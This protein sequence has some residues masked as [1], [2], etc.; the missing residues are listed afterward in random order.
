MLVLPAAFFALS[1]CA[2]S[3]V[4][5]NANQLKSLQRQADD[6]E[7]KIGGMNRLLGDLETRVAGL[8]EN[9]GEIEALMVELESARDE[10]KRKLGR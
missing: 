10:L 8:N 7:Q 2:G 9:A 1:G 3:K 5:S 4:K 6:M